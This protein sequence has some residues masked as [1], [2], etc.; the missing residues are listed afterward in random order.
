MQQDDCENM[1]MDKNLR[2]TYYDH[3]Q[4]PN[5]IVYLLIYC[6]NS[7]SAV[8]VQGQGVNNVQFDT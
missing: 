7:K 5:L 1:G 8:P 6:D 2:T 3:L 4:S